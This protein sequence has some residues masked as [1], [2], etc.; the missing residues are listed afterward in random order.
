MESLY[1]LDVL[2]WIELVGLLCVLGLA[3]GFIAGL[4]GVGGGTVIVPG[5]YLIFTIL[6]FTGD[7]LMHVC[8][9]TSLAI[10][11][12]TGFS[13]ARAHYKRGAVNMELVKRIGLGIVI[14]VILATALASH[15]SS[16]MMKRF[17][18]VAIAIL[19]VP[20]MFLNPAKIKGLPAEPG[21]PWSALAGI[22]NGFVAT[23]AGVGGGILNVPYMAFCGVPL[24]TAIGTAAALGLVIAIP[25]A[26]GF[27]VIGWHETGLPPYSLGFVNIPAFLAIV[28]FTM[29][30]A[31]IGA[32]TAHKAD[33]N[34]LRRLFAGFM[35]LLA[36]KMG[37][38]LT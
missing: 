30:S 6:G 31:K 33:V 19:S 4:L 8:V 21:Q 5:L 11:I 25:A 28:P 9:G 2:Q 13:S 20:M 34:L 14:G 26:A 12:F 22:S 37:I 27:V 16:D 1:S 15:M 24:H 36:I 18:A 17:F 23:L 3:A 38:D 32:W 29:P 10:I 35:V 7:N